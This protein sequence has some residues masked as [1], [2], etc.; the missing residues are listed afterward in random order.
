MTE[1]LLEGGPVDIPRRW[2]TADP[3]HIRVPR[4][5]GYEHFEPTG[6][7]DRVGDREVA[8]YRWSYR[9]RVAE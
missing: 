3:G 8:V 7:V 2:Q 9:T 5:A 6:R 1:V 4:M